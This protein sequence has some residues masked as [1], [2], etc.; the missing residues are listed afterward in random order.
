M[1]VIA[2]LNEGEL[3]FWL[4]VFGSGWVEDFVPILPLTLFQVSQFGR[5]NII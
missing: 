3:V 5:L 1:L 2:R 4:D